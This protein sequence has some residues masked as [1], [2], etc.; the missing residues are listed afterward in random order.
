MNFFK[1]ALKVQKVKWGR[2]LLLLAVLQQS[3]SSFLLD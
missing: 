3:L 1:R 2:S